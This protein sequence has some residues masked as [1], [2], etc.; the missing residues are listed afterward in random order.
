MLRPA[1]KAAALLLIHGLTN[2]WRLWR[3]YLEPLGASHELLIPDIRGH[4]DT[5]NPTP[6]L[7]A[8]Q[9]AREGRGCILSP[10]RID[11]VH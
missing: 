8:M 9:I 10:R 5:P 2:T 6:T 1:V 11:A 3:P 4:G 7:T